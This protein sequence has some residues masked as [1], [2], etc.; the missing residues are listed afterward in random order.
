MIQAE[1]SECALACLAMVA[2]A[3]GMQV[4]LHE[5]RRRFPLSLKGAT[6]SQLIDCAKRLNFSARPL[7]LDLDELDKLVLPCI[8]HWDLNHF[9]VLVAINRTRITILDPACGERT[10]SSLQLSRHFTG[11]AL[12]LVPTDAFQ[13]V[14]AKPALTL[15]QLTGRLRGLGSAL[16]QIL[17]LSLALQVFAILAPFFCSGQSTKC[18]LPQTGNY[19]PFLVSVLR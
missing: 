18:W 9:V 6:L 2:D 19:S 11:V 14:K 3:H 8:L 15:T 4:G 7:R 10:L 17:L 5:L 1:S 13:P 12:E 16:V